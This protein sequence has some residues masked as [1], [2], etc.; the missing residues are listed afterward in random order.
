MEWNLPTLISSLAQSFLPAQWYGDSNVTA[1]YEKLILMAAGYKSIK[2]YI[3]AFTVSKERFLCFFDKNFKDCTT[4]TEGASVTLSTIHSAKG[5]EWKNVFIIG[6]NDQNFPG[7]KKYDNVYSGY[8]FC[9]DCG[10]PMFAMSRKDMLPAYTC[11]AYHRRGREAC[12]SHHIR[13]DILDG[14]LKLYVQDSMRNA[15]AILDRINEDLSREETDIAKTESSADHLYEILQV[16][17][18]E[19]KAFLGEE[20][21]VLPSRDLTLYDTA[22]VSRGWEQKRLRQLYPQSNIVA[23]DYDPGASEVNQLNRIKL[24][25]AQA[26]KNL[27]EREEAVK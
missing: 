3:D 22:V 12:T 6:M 26:K 16:L 17:Q 8:L 14:M 4:E 20:A 10:S 7:I 11:G 21:P 15:A 19:L 5:L 9:G 1:D 25:L 13:V 18:E 24:M 2:E 23:V 27:A